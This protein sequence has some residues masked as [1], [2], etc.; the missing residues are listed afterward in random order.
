MSILEIRNPVFANEEGNIINVEILLE[1]WGEF[2][3]FSAS[4]QDVEEHGRSIFLRALEGEF[5]EVS[6][7]VPSQE[8]VAVRDI[9]SFSEFRGRFTKEELIRIRQVG[10]ETPEVYVAWEDLQ[11]MGNIKLNDPVVKETMEVFYTFK[12][13]TKKRIGE[14]LK[15]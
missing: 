2:I 1:G 7:Y 12:V 14:I 6:P 5:G 8:P 15:I 11:V 10:L 13:F 9:I 4:P 3:P